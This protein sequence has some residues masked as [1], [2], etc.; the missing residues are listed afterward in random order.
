MKP[1]AACDLHP[2][3]CQVITTSRYSVLPRMRDV[4]RVW[5]HDEAS[6]S[7]LPSVRSVWNRICPGSC[8][9]QGE[10]TQVLQPK[11]KWNW[12][13]KICIENFK[14]SQKNFEC[15]NMGLLFLF[16]VSPSPW[17]LVVWWKHT[18]VQSS[19]PSYLLA[20]TVHY[21]TTAL[22]LLAIGLIE[23]IQNVGGWCFQ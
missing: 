10:T 18:L 11:E 20:W 15:C 14:L 8:V 3:K 21:N 16:S 12:D 5:G 22:Q 17:L 13:T 1:Q 2:F 4:P 19:P 9:C 7:L 6:Q 23:T